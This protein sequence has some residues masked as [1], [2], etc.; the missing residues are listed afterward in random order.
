MARIA[1]TGLPVLF[2]PNCLVAQTAY[3]KGNQIFFDRNLYNRLSPLNQAAL[4]LHE[5]LY[6]IAK[7]DGA[8]DASKIY[9][10][11]SLFLRSET[12]LEGIGSEALTREFVKLLFT[13][14]DKFLTMPCSTQYSGTKVSVRILVDHG[15]ARF[16]YLAQRTVLDAFG[17][18]LDLYPSAQIEECVPDLGDA[19]YLYAPTDSHRR[20]VG[21]MGIGDD[22][23][24]TMYIT[25]IKLGNATRPTIGRYS[26]KL[27]FLLSTAKHRYDRII[28]EEGGW[29]VLSD[30]DVTF[31]H[32][33][34][35]IKH[36]SGASLTASE[37]T[38][39]N[40]GQELKSAA[41]QQDLSI[42]PIWN[43]K[44]FRAG[45]RVEFDKNGEIRLAK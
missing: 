38:V 14:E 9:D 30:G 32:T 31:K 19:G 28:D 2:S 15:G 13:E 4:V 11:V 6:A 18:K 3:R 8:T 43:R 45:A 27:N 36:R 21:Q 7:D 39:G 22:L 29:F 34:I 1:D 44:H 5:A 25:E 41:L 16:A 20:V 24:H 33:T 10:L 23:I 40:F 35:K 17:F 12:D 37:V 26:G 42:G